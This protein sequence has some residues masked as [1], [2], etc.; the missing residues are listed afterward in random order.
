MKTRYWIAALVFA[1]AVL[2][3]GGVQAADVWPSKPLRFILPAQPGTSADAAARI[4]AQELAKIWKQ[5]VIVDNRP[6]AGGI[7]ATQAVA[8][9]PADGYTF[10]W[11]LAAHAINPSLYG[12]LPYDTLH[13]LSGVTLLYSLKCV[14]VSAPSFPA[15]DVRDL[16]EVARNSS[17]GLNYTSAFTGSIPHLL[18]EVFKETNRIPMQYIGYKGSVAA[19]TD[20]MGG[21]VPVMFDVLPGALTHIRAGR[22]KA[23]AIVGDVPA[24]ELPAVPVLRGLLPKGAFAGWNGIVVPAGTPQSTISKLHADIVAIARSHAVEERFAALTVDPVS[25]SP[26]EFDRFIQDEIARWSDVIRR[27]GIKLE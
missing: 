22:L 11:V 9:A 12:K 15:K 1:L 16:V 26:D 2:V 23:L 3:A 24:R 8:T 17:A 18:G 13:D 25:N 20:V 7:V 14:L 10:G 27:T 4:L 6:S 19:E 5:P 21:R